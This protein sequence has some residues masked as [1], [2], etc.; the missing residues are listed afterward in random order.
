MGIK[1]IKGIKTLIPPKHIPCINLLLHIIQTSIIPIGN[2]SITL[3]LEFS[4]IIH[5]NTIYNSLSIQPLH[6]C[7]S[8]QLIKVRHSQSQVSISKQLHRLSLLHSTLLQQTGKSIS[9]SNTI[10]LCQQTSHRKPHITSTCN[11][12]FHISRIKQKKLK[13]HPASHPE[14][15]S[16]PDL[17]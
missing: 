6:L 11:C 1:G 3:P 8:I 4:K 5:H 7:I 17:T 2:N 15:R 13:T 14:K 12:H 16:V 10:M 9:R